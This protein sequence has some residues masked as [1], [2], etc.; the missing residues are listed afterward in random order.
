MENPINDKYIPDC[1]CPPYLIAD[2]KIGRKG[3]VDRPAAAQNED[4]K[5]VADV[6]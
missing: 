1:Y 4:T 3:I 5:S 2:W 6:T